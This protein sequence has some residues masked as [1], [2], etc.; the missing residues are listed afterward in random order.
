MPR[1]RLFTA[2]M[3][4]CS[5]AAWVA[6]IA[7]AL[8]Q[9]AAKPIT[10]RIGWQPLAGG[11][12]AI[13]MVMQ[14]DRLFEAAGEKRGYQITPEWN[15]FPAGPPSNEA[16]IGGQLDIDMHLSALPT[17]NRIAV[18]VPAVPIAVV[19]SNIA[20]AI[21]VAPESPIDEVSKLAGATVGLPVGTSAHYVLASIVRAHFGSSIDEAG[22]SLVN[23]PVTE[24]VKIPEGIDAAAVWV[25]LRFIGPIQG[26]SELL[27]DANGWTGEGHARPGIRASEVEQS[28]AYPEGYNT[29][30][31]YAF[32]RTPFLTE[33]P[34]VVLAFI[35]AH[36][37]AQQTL[38]D[39]F[40]EAVEM[41]NERWKQPDII[42][43]TT[44]ETYAE[45]SGVRKAPFILE[46]DVATILKASEFLASINV[47][48][49]ALTWDEIKAAFIQSAALQQRAWEAGPFQPSLE[50]MSDGFS[51]ETELYGPIHINGGSPVWEW[52]ET[53]DWGQRV[54]AE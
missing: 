54:L 2:L 23:M 42:A 20:N 8:A 29:D 4:I 16:M 46:W 21:M 10:V 39:Q 49:R 51:G 25:P 19:G 43:R 9:D 45:T 48:D 14:R 28:W 3:L 17:V 15:T 35:E 44:L 50:Q 5:A 27:V 11:S 30:R 36:M 32:A 40:E 34:D 31:L 18:G 33:H 24:G 22:I 13:A 7:P 6:L 12:A 41:A 53:P 37:A 38:L 47:L 26:L 1:T 52:D